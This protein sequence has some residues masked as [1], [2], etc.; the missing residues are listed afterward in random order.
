MNSGQVQEPKLTNIE[1]PA[2]A[3]FTKVWGALLNRSTNF[4]QVYM[5]CESRKKVDRMKVWPIETAALYL[6]RF[7]VP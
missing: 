4:G 7:K 3:R 1:R 2:F 6:Y 5:F